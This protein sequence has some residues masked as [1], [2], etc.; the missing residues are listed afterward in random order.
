MLKNI[1]GPD[2]PHMTLWRMRMACWVPK[3]TTRTLGIRTTYCFSTATMVARTLLIVTLYVHCLSFYALRP[4]SNY[5]GSVK[6]T[7]R[8][9]CYF[10]ENG[11]V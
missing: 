6:C 2:T 4:Y 3:V 1:A 5:T 7:S 8:L 9:P 11:S 10:G